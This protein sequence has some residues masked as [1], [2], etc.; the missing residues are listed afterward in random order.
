MKRDAILLGLIFAGLL[1]LALLSGCN[2][3][4][5]VWP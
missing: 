2:T 3:T 4:W 5:E 1:T